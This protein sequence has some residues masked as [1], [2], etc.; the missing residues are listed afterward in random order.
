MSKHLL[1]IGR[2]GRCF[3]NKYEIIRQSP[4]PNYQYSPRRNL[5]AASVQMTAI[6]QWHNTQ[7]PWLSMSENKIISAKVSRGRILC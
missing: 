4:P 5:T 1:F 3:N 2:H 6:N 7:Q